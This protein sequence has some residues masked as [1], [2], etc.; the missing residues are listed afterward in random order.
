L[1]EPDKIFARIPYLNKEIYED[2]STR[3]L[4]GLLFYRKGDLKTAYQFI[5]DLESPNSEN[6][7]GNLYL[8]QKKYEL[9]YAQFKVALNKKKNS[10]NALERIIPVAWILRQWQD[11]LKFTQ[12]IEVSKKDEPRRQL[13]SAAFQTQLKDYAKARKGLEKI[14]HQSN[15]TQSPQANQLLTYVTLMQKDL[16]AT[17]NY[18]RL[19]CNDLRGLN[20]WLQ[21]H[22]SS[23]DDF[24]L[25][26]KRDEN[27]YTEKSLLETY[28]SGLT[29]TPMQENIFIGQQD[30]E[31]L[32][33]II[34]QKYQ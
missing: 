26:I 34:L 27:I 2:D 29:S 30:I 28:R 10:Q 33:H 7:K 5:E 8:A 17:Q 1:N 11:G 20:C 15:L 25:T 6:I 19:A 9:A 31:E 13:I 24:S 4:L 3:E 14:V 22:L 32:D 18:N 23:W 21:F 16:S 12:S